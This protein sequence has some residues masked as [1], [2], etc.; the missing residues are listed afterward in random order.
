MSC[1]L[2]TK[3]RRGFT[4]IETLV[5]IGV[6]FTVG[7]FII[8][9]FFSMLKSGAKSTV[10]TTVEQNGNYALNVMSR[11]IQNSREVTACNSDSLTIKNPDDLSTTFFCDDTSTCDSASTSPKIASVS[12]A[13]GNYC[14]TSDS[15]IADCLALFNCSQLTTS[16]I[17]GISFGVSQNIPNSKLEETA[18]ID[19]QTNVTIRNY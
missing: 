4:L 18:Q 14:L 9:L 15:V 16:R 12:A 1:Q 3:N 11:M 6:L 13:T 10:T 17:I 19:F 7:I 5:V 2:K 8:Q